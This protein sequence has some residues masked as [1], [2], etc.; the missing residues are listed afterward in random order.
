MKDFACRSK[1]IKDQSTFCPKKGLV[2]FDQFLK[3]IGYFASILLIIF[4]SI[5]L[6][7]LPLLSIDD[8]FSIVFDITNKDCNINK[9]L[10]AHYSPDKRQLRYFW[11]QPDHLVST[12]NFREKIVEQSKLNE[13][14]TESQI[15]NAFIVGRLV[16]H[17]IKLEIGGEQSVNCE[18]ADNFV[19]DLVPTG[20]QM[21]LGRAFIKEASFS[22]SNIALWATLAQAQWIEDDPPKTLNT[23]EVPIKTE[24]SVAVI[25]ATPVVGYAQLVT[26]VLENSGMRVIKLDS[27]QSESS[28]SEII[29]SPDKDC[30]VTAGLLASQLFA[31]QNSVKLKC[32]ANQISTYRAD[33]IIRLAK[34]SIENNNLGQ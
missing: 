6:L 29:F 24:C 4:L 19:K 15:P 10:F 14:L 3:T 22:K 21:K 18:S 28:I 17:W 13:L 1:Q 23:V 8:D 20:I 11:L 32:D 16:H 12:P 30:E 33:I 9:Y 26:Q 2:F 5:W 34:P 7:F 27:E 25:N 31:D